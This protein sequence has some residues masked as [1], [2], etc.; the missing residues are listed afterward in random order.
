MKFLFDLF[1]ILLFFGAYSYTQDIFIATATAIVATFGQ[2]IYSWVRHRKVDTMLW[3]SLVLITVLGGATLIFHNKTF[4][5]WKPTVLYW[6]FAL[7]LLGTWQLKQ[8]NLI[9]KL[10][11][12]QIALERPIWTRLLLAWSVFF[13]AMGFVNLFVAYQFDEAIWVKFKLFGF[14]ALMLVFVVAQSLYL[15]RH[16]QSEADTPTDPK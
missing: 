6:F 10:M 8:I 11:N 9:E 15:S 13:A 16:I 3:I 14:T 12:G 4:I 1:P 7:A 5:L 2:V